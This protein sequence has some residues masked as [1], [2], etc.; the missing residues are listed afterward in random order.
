MQPSLIG[1]LDLNMGNIASVMNAI[2][3][4]GFDTQ[5]VRESDD[6]VNITHL[7]IPGV[8][9]YETAVQSLLKG[10]LVEPIKEFV[11]QQHPVLG[12]CLGM[13]LLHAGSEESKNGVEGLGLLSGRFRRFNGEQRVPHIGWNDVAITSEHPLFSGIKSGRDF[14]FVHSY[15]LPAEADNTVLAT[16]HYE[17][18]FVSSSGSGSV[19]GVQFHPEKSQRNGLQLLENFCV[20]GGQC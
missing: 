20:W 2:D 19:V 5:V 4:C 10:G 12:I 7:I 14:Y 15:C 17:R 13:Q 9:H 11:E 1:V 8:G 16:T 3:Y 18:P 6:F